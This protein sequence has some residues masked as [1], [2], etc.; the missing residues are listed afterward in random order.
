VQLTHRNICPTF[1]V[2]R[3]GDSY[4]LA[5]E[6]VIGRDVRTM[7]TELMQHGRHM[8]EA[9]ALHIVCEALDALDYAHRHADPVSG[10][11]LHLVHRDVSPQNVMINVEGEVKLIDFGLAPRRATHRASA[12]RP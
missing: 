8:P 4:Y 12:K 1:D 9:C 7:H 6:L 11:P 5:M 2:G 10:E 3:V